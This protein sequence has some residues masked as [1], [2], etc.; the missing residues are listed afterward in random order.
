MDAAA[1]PKPKRKPAKKRKRKVGRP[2]AEIS[3]ARYR[4]LCMF[5]FTDEELAAALNVSKSTIIQLRKEPAFAEAW[6]RGQAEGRVR[7]KRRGF[8]LMKLNNSAGV[9]AW[10]EHTRF[11]LGWTEKR[12]VELTGQNGGPIQHVD[13]SKATDE[14]LAALEALF[15][16][17]ALAA[18]DDGGDQ[19]GADTAGDRAGA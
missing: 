3:L 5:Q 10:R 7:V 15:G 1:A 4:R 12:L 17:L 13:L 8:E 6:E 16:P 9:Q 2:R 14:Q 18:S 19:G 11:Y